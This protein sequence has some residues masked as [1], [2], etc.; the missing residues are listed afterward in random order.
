MRTLRFIVD[1]QLIKQDPDCDFSGLVPGSKGYLRAE[2]AFSSE[3]ADCAKIASFYSTM[4]RELP[5]R[6][7]EDGKSCLIPEEALKKRSFKIQLLGKYGDKLLITNKVVVNQNG[8][9]S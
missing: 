4:G 7:L 6:I 1:N 2:F 5:Y 8:G 3:W 9:K